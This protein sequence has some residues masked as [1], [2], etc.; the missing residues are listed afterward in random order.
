M[1]VFLFKKN[2][3]YKGKQKIAV[4]PKGEREEDEFQETEEGI[5]LWK[6]TILIE[7]EGRQDYSALTLSLILLEEPDFYMVPG[8][9]YNGNHWGEGKEPKGLGTEEGCWKF[10]SHR[11]TIPA[12]MYCQNTQGAFGLYGNLKNESGFSC[13][14]IRQS[15]GYFTMNLQ[16]P[17]REEPAVYCARDSYEKAYIEP[18]LWKGKKIELYAVLVLKERKQKYDYDKFLHSAWEQM[19]D[20]EETVRNKK[21]VWELGFSFLKDSAFFRE[22]IFSGFCMGLTWQEK[23]WIQ[24]RDYLEFGWVG[25]NGSLAVSFLYRYALE[26]NEEDLRIGLE[27]LD[28]WA[29]YAPLQ[30]GLFRC[31]FDRIQKYG[32]KTDNR[33]ERN[34]AANLCAVVEEY[35]EAYYLLKSLGKEGGREN[36]RSLAKNICRFIIAVQQ[37]NGRLGKAWYNDGSCSDEAG[38]I[39]C[40]LAKA[41]C[42]AYRYE[43]DE[44]YLKA[45]EKSYHYYY[46]EFIQY[47]YTTAGA[48]D[49]YCVDKES[50]I[51]LLSTALELYES[52]KK[53]IYLKQA[54]EISNYL[55][56]WQYHY[57]VP[58]KEA[59]LLW[60]MHYC[61]RGGTAVSVQHNHIDCYGLEFYEDWI[62][63]SHLTGNSYWEERARAIWNN[64]LYNISD[65]RL[66]IKGQRRPAGSQDEGFLQ[67]RWHT[68]RGEYF[69]VSEWLVVWNT[70]FRLKI[71]RKEYLARKR[72]LCKEKGEDLIKDWS[73]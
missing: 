35:L 61:T 54:V 34:D 45:A 23:Q 33:E 41:L 64:S 63:L 65:G 47:G 32:E 21:E 14:M 17:E 15:E 22:G 49:T 4:I 16:F 48:L 19:K 9:N 68:K 5:F 43:K 2:G 53:E 62:K 1:G 8:V 66:I 36:Y 28:S 11:A 39:G 59:T 25:Q 67:T 10:A 70:A 72:G 46:E 30:N 37:E 69:G 13:F 38:T 56:T 24:K 27:I 7:K 55:A 71:L 52:R 6:R 40:Y 31:R 44:A 12:G 29:R 58:F 50:A 3:L 57:N 73:L 42:K 26:G 51:P 18:F 20:K 60:Q